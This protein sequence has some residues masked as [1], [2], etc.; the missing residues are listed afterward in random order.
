MIDFL[1]SER[2]FVDH[3]VPVWEA[4]PAECRGLFFVTE[5]LVEDGCARG[6]AVEPLSLWR[7]ASRSGLAACASARDLA[8][9]TRGGRK[10]ALFEHGAGQSYQ[11][12]HTSYAGGPGRQNVVLFLVPG[13]AP[14]ARN[15]AAYP[16]VPVVEIGC[17]KMD[18]WHQ[19]YPWGPDEL[20]PPVVAL[21]W[22]WDCQVCPETR[23]AW[24][25]FRPEL[26]ELAKRTD[27]RLL[28][29]AHPR[30]AKF[31]FP[32]Y[33]KLGIEIVPDFEE[34]LRRADLYCCDNSSTLFEFASTGRP[35]LV[36]NAPWYRRQVQHGLRFW[37]CAAVG[38]QVGQ[39]GDLSVAIDEALLDHPER[40]QA[41]RAA[42]AQVYA[43]TDGRASQRAAEALLEADERLP[44]VPPPAKVEVG[45][46]QLECLV[47]S[48][49]S[50]GS[51]AA[52]WQIRLELRQVTVFTESGRAHVA[53]FH[54]PIQ[55]ELLADQLVA[56]G[57]FRRR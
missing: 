47:E 10:V 41:R 5:D 16:G 15:R 23:S 3:L 6:L 18:P 27:I 11:T 13:P 46:H 49:F 55:P 56:Q 33:S 31:I 38:M 12:A 45:E 42:V 24:E 20:E 28:G 48:H 8:T 40:Q 39:S 30:A 50:W 29:H 43:A 52:G 35:V 54:A 53:R 19:P 22:H 7:L 17:P 2:H 4:L 34:V 26:P 36:L 51:V 1:A 14:A 37:D 25:H 21:S 32:T 9:L 57:R 44:L